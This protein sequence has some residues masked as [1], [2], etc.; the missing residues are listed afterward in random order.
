[1][2]LQIGFLHIRK[3]TIMPSSADRVLFIAAAKNAK[4]DLPRSLLISG[5]YPIGASYFAVNEALRGPQRHF[6]ASRQRLAASQ[7]LAK[8]EEGPDAPAMCPV[9]INRSIDATRIIRR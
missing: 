7:S 5:H 8:G 4:T 9:T 6:N 3:A 2:A 1:M